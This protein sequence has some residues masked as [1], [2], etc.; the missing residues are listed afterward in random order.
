MY[1]F[2]STFIKKISTFVTLWYYAKVVVG[3]KKTRTTNSYEALIM[4]P[5][6]TLEFQFDFCFDES[7]RNISLIKF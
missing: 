5:S 6:S 7:L 1:T 4:R 2:S 3:L